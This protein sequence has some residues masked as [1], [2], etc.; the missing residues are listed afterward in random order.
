MGGEI[1]ARQPA[2]AV[3]RALRAPAVRMRGAVHQIEERIDGANRGIVFVLAK[4]VDRLG[5]PLLHLGLG[6]HRMA[7]RVEHDRQH[8][9][10]IL[11]Q[12]GAAHR[13]RMARGRDA[14]RDAALVELF[15]DDVCR[16]GVRFPDRARA[17]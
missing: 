1:G 17:R 12:A 2:D 14:Q 3:D 16:D 7:H 11:G 10:E 9:V 5:A 15:R 8:V 6:E 13:G 4:R